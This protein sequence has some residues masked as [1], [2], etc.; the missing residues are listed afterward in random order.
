M[1]V[2]IDIDDPSWLAIDNIEGE[3]QRI[4]DHCARAVDFG[5][6]PAEATILFSDDKTVAELNRAWRGKHG[7]TNVLSFP[8][9]PG[10]AHP[11]A[12]RHVGDIALAFG[13][14]AREAKEQGKALTA[15]TS[16]LLVHGL[17]H[18]AG[19]DHA[20]E[21]EAAIMEARESEI[22]SGLGIADPYASEAGA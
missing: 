6:E 2:S 17:L 19:F 8:A 18:L 16:H 11:D 1:K 7:P 10:I 3:T 20:S 4:A 15:H 12:P 21:A 22:L 9:A 13:V 5:G 14:V